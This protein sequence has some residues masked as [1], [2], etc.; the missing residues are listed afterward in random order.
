MQYADVTNLG[1][2]NKEGFIVKA[3]DGKYGIVDYSN[4]T[5]SGTHH[6][7]VEKGSHRAVLQWR[8]WCFPVP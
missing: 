8:N 3:E 1:K 5:V 2:D 4:Q 6:G 7:K